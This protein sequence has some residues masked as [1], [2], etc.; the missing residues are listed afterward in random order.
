[1]PLLSRPKV[2]SP[3]RAQT[4]RK[5]KKVRGRIAPGRL[6]PSALAQRARL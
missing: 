4:A 3:I 2:S 6:D 1:V 5:A